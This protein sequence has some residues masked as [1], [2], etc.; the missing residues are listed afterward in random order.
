MLSRTSI[1]RNLLAPRTLNIFLIILITI[2]GAVLRFYKL[3]S[4]SFWYDE[5]SSI[6][7]ARGN[8]YNVSHPPLSFLILRIVIE[9]LGTTEFT[10]RLPSCLFG[11]VTIPLVYLF[12]KQLFGEKEGLVASFIIS[13]SPWY[14][15]WSQEA[16]MYTELTVFTILAL[17]FF[18]RT[19]YKKTLTFY[20]LSVIFTILAFYTHYL[21]ILILVIIA[22]WLISIKFF[23]KTKISINYKYLITFFALFFIFTLPLFLTIIPQTLTFKIGSTNSRWGLPIHIYFLMLF[24]DAIGPTLSLFSMV[25]VIYLISQRNRAGY[26]LTAY[27]AIPVATVSVLTFV[28]NVV[29]RY[30]IFTL[31]AFALLSS[32]LIIEI[33]EEI[34]KNAKEKKFHV[35]M[36]KNLEL[37][38]FLALGFVFAT[39][40][41]IINL[42]TLFEHYTKE[43]HPDWKSACAYV[44]SNMEPEDLI[45]TTGDKAVDYYLGKVDYRL[46]IEFFEPRDLEEIQ[47]SEEKVWLLIDKGRIPSIDPDYEFRA[48][49]ESDCELMAEPYSIKVYLFTPQSR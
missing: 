7:D 14:I 38:K 40:I 5:A 22:A 36:L 19:I 11:I 1:K 12:G 2:I 3:G 21:A 17:Y 13:L 37:N 23:E 27:A 35:I 47:N 18:Y 29:P 24:E 39:V 20:V 41:S 32:S 46:S 49:L 10:A 42:P 9:T 25:G 31:P 6:L 34:M 43:T 33:F 30:V 48:W 45:A 26:L 28:T 8:L 4:Q 44:A 15:R 16:R